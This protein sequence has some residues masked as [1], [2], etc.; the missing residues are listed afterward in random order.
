MMSLVGRGD[1]PLTRTHALSAT[2]GCEDDPGSNRERD[3][4][5]ACSTEGNHLAHHSM[6]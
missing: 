4:Q 5:H 2:R 1:G 3:M 6:M